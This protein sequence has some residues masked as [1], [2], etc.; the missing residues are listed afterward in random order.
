MVNEI[1]IL[2]FVK[3]PKKEMLSWVS[4]KTKIKRIKMI[5][6]LHIN[7][8]KCKFFNTHF[9]IWELLR[10]TMHQSVNSGIH[11]SSVSRCFRKGYL[12]LFP[13]GYKGGRCIYSWME[14]ERHRFV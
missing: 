6:F 7:I 14:N 1:L 9:K 5:S 3:V 2:L 4:Y 11:F 10:R 13:H 12:A 8:E